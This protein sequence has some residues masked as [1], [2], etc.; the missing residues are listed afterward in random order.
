[1]QDVL[2]YI[3]TERFEFSEDHIRII[4]ACHALFEA[5]RSRG[6]TECKIPELE[7]VTYRRDGLGNGNFYNG[8]NNQPLTYK[9]IVSRATVPQ[10]VASIRSQAQVFRASAESTLANK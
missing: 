10:I 9:E 4:D 6:V 1:M 5:M 8:N 2:T 7:G 3:L